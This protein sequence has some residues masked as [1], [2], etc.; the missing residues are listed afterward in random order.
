MFII[1]SPISIKKNQ[2][3]ELNVVDLGINAEG[4]AKIDNFIIF[5][6]FAL[7]SEV[8]IAKIIKVTKN[9]AIAKLLEVLVSSSSRVH[10]KCKYYSLCG[11]CN[12]QHLDYKEQLVFKQ[13]TVQN[14]LKKIAGISKEIIEVKET[15]G[16]EDPWR[17]RNKASFPV[18]MRGDSVNIGFYKIKSHEIV[19]IDGCLIQNSINEN[20]LKL[21]RKFIDDSGISIYDE[22]TQEGL[23]KHVVT[24]VNN[25]G[26]V[27]VCVVVNERFFE[28]I[29]HDKLV[30][31]FCSLPGI[32]SVIVNFNVMNNN[33]ILGEKTKSLVGREYIE[34]K[35]GDLKFFIS[36]V[37]F[38]QVNT[39][40]AYILYK[41]ALEYCGLTGEE[42]IF[43]LYCGIGSISLF[44]AREAKF[45]Y[46][47]EIVH[48]SIKN[49]KKNAKINKISN[50]EFIEGKSEEVIFDLIDERAVT[51]D[52]IVLDPP[53][54][55]CDQALIEAIGKAKV[56][57]IVY[58]SCD[59]ATLARDIKALLWYGY[60]LKKVQ[61]VDM[62][63]LTSHV[64]VVALIE[65]AEKTKKKK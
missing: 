28:N 38:F 5:I 39:D 49:A 34:D 45:V 57:K 1:L 9:Y 14:N 17:Y 21:I 40:Q 37:A 35:I 20:I 58:I 8:V 10:P 62:F 65:L 56:K 31:T 50:V 30:H 18:S 54:K 13:N 42:V 61:P 11:G 15:L 23:L 27:M 51:P 7:P 29:Y 44:L 22:K 64:E 3:L 55:G 52:V 43:D 47:V 59:N 25:E 4:I 2:V 53:R 6:P 19:D 60:E 63:C 32:V 36:T 16:M 26:K 33:V 46:G 12:L 24:R 41:K 48:K